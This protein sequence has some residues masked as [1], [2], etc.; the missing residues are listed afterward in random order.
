MDKQW[1]NTPFNKTD[2]SGIE[3]L[4]QVFEDPS[5]NTWRRS[6]DAPY[7]HWKMENN[8]HQT[9]IIHV[10]KSEQEIVGMVSITPKSAI[11]QK[12]K[13][14]AAELGDCFI[15][16]KKNQ[17]GMFASLLKSTK[18][19]AL[20]S[21][22]QFLYGT[23]N[24]IALP[25]E[26]KAGYEIIP[27]AKVYNLIYPLDIGAILPMKIE[28]RILSSMVSPIISIGYKILGLKR[29]LMFRNS[30]LKVESTSQFP[31]EIEKLFD[32]CCENYDL[33]L[34]RKKNYLDWRFVE[35]PD[36]YSIYL[37]RYGKMLIGY[38]VTKNGSWNSLSVGYVADYLFDEKYMKFFP[39]II[40]LILSSFDK[41]NIQMISM[42]STIENPFYNAARS[43]GFL[44][45]QPV[46]V[47]CYKNSF[48]ESILSADLKWHFTMADSDN[49]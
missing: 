3:R 45:Y 49:I 18:D 35:N 1:E 39:R 33:I 30:K 47:I 36:D 15:N 5:E 28:S 41:P 22:V 31:E 21:G 40:E 23:P 4:R 46:P 16:P 44:K 25:G 8:Y 14:N 7:Y 17:R 19:S 13:M 43:Y 34:E 48:G 24:S 9:G 10:A 27:S 38:F 29:Y 42:W 26:R 6:I 20:E 37:V 11:I 32:R 2:F 12:K